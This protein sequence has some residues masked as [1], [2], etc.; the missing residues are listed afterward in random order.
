LRLTDQ[1]IIEDIRNGGEVGL[2]Q[3]YKQYRSEFL[4]WSNRNFNIGDEASADLFQDTIIN[5]RKNIV[6]G[7]LTNLT[8]SLKTYLFAIGKNLALTRLKKD[9]RMIVDENFMSFQVSGELSTDTVLEVN[10]NSTTIRE[11]MKNYF[12]TIIF[13]WNPLPSDYHTKMKM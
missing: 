1:N 4:S 6:K 12:I 13:Q 2:I 5:L 8:S 9:S 10:D 7:N 11:L 3:I